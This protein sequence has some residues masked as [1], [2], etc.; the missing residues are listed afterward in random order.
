MLRLT[1][2]SM[3]ALAL[4]SCTI[5]QDVDQFQADFPCSVDIRLQRYFPHA[6]DPGSDLDV[7]RSFELRERFGVYVVQERRS[8]GGDYEREYGARAFFD[9]LPAPNVDIRLP[10]AVDASETNDQLPATLELHA[11]RL[12]VMLATRDDID[13]D[14]FEFRQ[15]PTRQH[16]WILPHACSAENTEFPHNSQFDPLQPAEEEPL[17][18]KVRPSR[19]TQFQGFVQTTIEVRVE[20]ESDFE[21]QEVDQALAFYRRG[22]AD[23]TIPLMEDGMMRDILDIK[24]DVEID[25][26]GVLP[27][28]ED[29]SVITFVDRNGNGVYDTDDFAVEVELDFA[30]T[31]L[32]PCNAG[33]PPARFRACSDGDDIIVEVDLEDETGNDPRLIQEA[34]WALAPAPE[35]E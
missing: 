23:R 25:L 30:T 13:L 35:D 7:S 24:E 33:S 17:G 10:F 8:P 19:A 15:I 26:G 6:Q 1:A 3:F 34:W 11:D 16:S 18:L 29:I 2:I 14:F 20:R 27:D 22:A 31:G 12:T 32:P 5:I 28:D 4:G 21:G 9:P